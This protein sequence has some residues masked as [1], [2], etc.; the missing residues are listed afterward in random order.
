M[1]ETKTTDSETKAVFVYGCDFFNTYE[2]SEKSFAAIGDRTKEF[3]DALKLI[4]GRYNQYLKINGVATPGWIFSKKHT[5]KFGTMMERI[6]TL[7]SE[8][9]DDE[10]IAKELMKRFYQ[11]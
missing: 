4:G 6:N 8:D 1:S 3:K 9:I 5:E 2:Y 10:Q 7:V 11:T